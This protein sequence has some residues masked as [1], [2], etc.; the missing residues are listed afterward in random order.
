VITTAVSQ[1]EVNPQEWGALSEVLARYLATRPRGMEALGKLLV[2]Q[3]G[4]ASTGDYDAKGDI[5]RLCSRVRGCPERFS[6]EILSL[7]YVREGEQRRKGA[8]R[9][10]TQFA[11]APPLMHEGMLGP[12]MLLLTRI[13]P[14]MLG[15]A[16]EAA[17]G[18]R[19]RSFPR[20]TASERWTRSLRASA[21]RTRSILLEG[22]TGPTTKEGDDLQYVP[23]LLRGLALACRSSQGVTPETPCPRVSALVLMRVL[24]A[25]PS[26]DLRDSICAYQAITDGAAYE[27]EVARYAATIMKREVIRDVGRAMRILLDALRCHPGSAEGGG[28]AL[29]VSPFDP[30]LVDLVR[31]NY[32]AGDMEIAVNIIRFVAMNPTRYPETVAELNRSSDPVVRE[33]ITEPP[34]PPASAS[35]SRIK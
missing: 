15:S 34:A 12:W 17:G 27:G 31:A 3:E 10:D 21:V 23:A 33:V 13:P 4:E 16:V 26:P 9:Q 2:E 18:R 20:G 22:F 29:R 35:A 5:L 30:L 25:V 32:P 24:S 28:D 8:S 11:G 1:E 6:V 7:F 19:L 14:Q